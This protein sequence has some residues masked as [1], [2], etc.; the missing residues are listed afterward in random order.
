MKQR[1]KWGVLLVNSWLASCTSPTEKQSLEAVAQFYGGSV[2]FTK[3]ANATTETA[4]A[5]G[6]YLEI[7]LNASGIG[8]RYSDLQIPASNCAHMVYEKFSP[9][10]QQA[11]DY[12]KVSLNDSGGAHAYTFRKTE[13]ATAA[14]AGLDLNA[15]MIDLQTED[16][17]K[18]LKAFNPEVLGAEAQAKL[19][20]QLAKIEQSV[21]SITDYR[22]EGYAPVTIELGKKEVK[23]VRFYLT[24]VHAGKTSRLS[25]LINPQMHPDQPFLYGMQVA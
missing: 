7:S 13:L 14:Q 18:V 10:E 21:A 15:F 6:K 25:L 4:V 8:K 23:L 2:G 1:Y 9:A 24:V 5:H 12:L 22:V 11:Y 3:G 17:D 19:P 20:E 16:H